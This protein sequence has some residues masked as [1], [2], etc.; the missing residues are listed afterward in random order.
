MTSDELR[1]ALDEL[2]LSRREA[3]DALGVCRATIRNWLSGRHAVP[4]PAQR[5]VRLWLRRSDLRPLGTE[6]V[7]AEEIAR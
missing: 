2:D 1:T 7:P 3:A 4:G 6:E 5:L